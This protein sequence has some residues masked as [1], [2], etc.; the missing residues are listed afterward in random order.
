MYSVSYLFGLRSADVTVQTETSSAAADESVI[1]SDVTVNDQPWA[2]YT[3][4]ASNTAN[5]LPSMLRTPRIG[6]SDDD[7]S[8]DG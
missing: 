8:H 3:S 7:A 5:T 6:C 2:T 4:T 1:E